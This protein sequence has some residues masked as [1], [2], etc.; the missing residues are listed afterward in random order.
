VQMYLIFALGK[1][2]VLTPNDLGVRKG[3]M[4]L[5]KM[6][7]MPTP[8]QVKNLAEKWPPLEPVGTFF[9]WRVLESE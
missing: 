4:K 7:E 2:D 8:K 9:A 1:L 5:Y 3:V 6:E